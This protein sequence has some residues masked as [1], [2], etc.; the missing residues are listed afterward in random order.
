MKKVENVVIENLKKE[1]FSE[2]PSEKEFIEKGINQVADFWDVEKDGTAEEFT[3]FI[4]E[5]L[6]TDEKEREEFF[7]KI[8]R[9][10]EY[11]FGH[12]IQLLLHL[13]EP[14]DLDIGELTKFD[15]LFSRFNPLNHYEEDMFGEKIAF[16]ILLN[17]PKFSLKQKKLLADKWTSKDLAYARVADSFDS[18][19]PA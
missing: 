5:Y 13:R 14:I 7:L 11:I 6:I 12:L 8:N 16:A 10:W 2:Y 18:R 1:L 15:L 3:Q 4:K 19:V 9:N 17:Y